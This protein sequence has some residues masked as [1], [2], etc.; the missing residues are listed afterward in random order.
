MQPLVSAP[1][2]LPPSPKSMQL[3]GAPRPVLDEKL[4]LLYCGFGH[5]LRAHVNVVHLQGQGTDGASV[6]T[7]VFELGSL[8]RL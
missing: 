1:A 6:H 4:H 2:S 7:R 5:L 3:G 8:A